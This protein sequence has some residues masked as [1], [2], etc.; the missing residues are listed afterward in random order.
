MADDTPTIL[1]GDFNVCPR[2]DDLAPGLLPPTDALVRPE[3]RSGFRRLLWMGLTDAV[4]ALHPQGPTFVQ[5]KTDICPIHLF[6][7][8]DAALQKVPRLFRREHLVLPARPF[9]QPE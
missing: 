5:G 1:A 9:S 6:L 4:R 2:D 3:T 8:C 7:D